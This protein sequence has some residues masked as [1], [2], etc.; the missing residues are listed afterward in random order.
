MLIFIFLFFEVVG[1]D[2]LVCLFL[3]LSF[4]W[5]FGCI[6]GVVKYLKKKWV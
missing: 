6:Y 1:G 3:G 2:R 4:F 5:F